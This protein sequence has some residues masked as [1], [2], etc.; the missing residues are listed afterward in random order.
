MTSA[1]G[2][3]A[4]FTRILL[5]IEGSE[6]DVGAER[7]GIALAAACGAP[8]L[9]VLPLVSNPEIEVVAPLLE[10]KAEAEAADKLER[11]RR[12]AAS[13]GVE[14]RGTVRLGET[15]YKEIVDEAT[16]R[17]AD[18]IVLRRRG[19]R[20]YLA[21]LLIGEMVHTVTGHASC[22]VLIVPRA[23]GMWSRGIVLA[24]D[25]SLHSDRAATVAAALAARHRLPLTVV[26]AA[27]DPRTDGP[28]AHANAERALTLVRNAGVEASARVENGKP[29]ET[30]L[31]AA[32]ESGADLI[33]VGR[34][35]INR[36]ER[37]LI[38]STSERV[39]GNANCPVLIVQARSG[40]QKT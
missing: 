33:V 1:N 25:G 30:I 2:S 20:G 5:A 38:G 19:K 35:G 40:Q 26:S 9:A 32:E 17:Q 34:R 12:S 23:A 22:D 6:F 28:A 13:Q 14:L 3:A 16:E 24:T 37:V 39:A 29:F 21:N 31:K 27:E 10:E 8:L 18:L 4:A 11:L 36:A 7:V 15:P